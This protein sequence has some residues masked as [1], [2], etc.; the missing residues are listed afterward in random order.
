MPLFKL[1]VNLLQQSP[2]L[3]NII[4]FIS[5]DEQVQRSVGDI[6]FWNG[7]MVGPWSLHIPVILQALDRKESPSVCIGCCLWDEWRIGTI[8]G[9]GCFVTVLGTWHHLPDKQIETTF[10][11][12]AV[13][14]GRHHW[15]ILPSDAPIA[16]M[17]DGR[18][19]RLHSSLNQCI[20]SN[21]AFDWRFCI[22]MLRLK[23]PISRISSEPAFYLYDIINN[24]DPVGTSN[25]HGHGPPFGTLV[26]TDR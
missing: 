9:V 15:H 14:L 22:E 16:S 2:T 5:V 23:D 18:K 13:A 3:L 6:R 17:S 7:Y 24:S 10:L 25:P 20:F 12:W 8:G 19:L 26:R 1:R 11:R 4:L 21:A